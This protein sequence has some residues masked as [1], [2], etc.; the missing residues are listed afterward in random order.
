[1]VFIGIIYQFDTIQGAG[2][3]MLTDGEKKEFTT[4]EWIDGVNTPAVGQKISYEIDGYRVHIKVASEADEVKIASQAK[5]SGR[6]DETSTDAALE[7]F[8]GVDEYIHYFSDMGFKRVKDEDS[9]RERTLTFRRYADGEASEVVIRQ[10]GS[11]I[12]VTQTV[13]GK[14]I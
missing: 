8:T 14:Q 3:I 5:T 11:K 10:S 4:D 6:K 2:L 1:M 7:K 13:N 12:S 9:G